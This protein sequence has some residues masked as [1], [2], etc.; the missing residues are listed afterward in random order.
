MSGN[1]GLTD[2]S[3]AADMP[4]AVE[5]KTCRLIPNHNVYVVLLM[6]CFEEVR[7]SM[8]QKG[9][10]RVAGERHWSCIVG[11]HSLTE[12]AL[13]ARGSYLID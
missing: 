5:E 11:L 4:W 10:K 3:I 8:L 1:Q 9:T 6:N 2:V 12:L 7:L 13:G